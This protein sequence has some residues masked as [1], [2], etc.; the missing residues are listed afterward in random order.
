[1]GCDLHKKDDLKMKEYKKTE[2]EKIF[3]NDGNFEPRN[4]YSG[5]DYTLEK[6]YALLDKIDKLVNQYYEMIVPGITEAPTDTN[7][8]Y[9]L[10]FLYWF[11]RQEKVNVRMLLYKS[12]H[13]MINK[14]RKASSDLIDEKHTEAN[15][16]LPIKANVSE[17]LDKIIDK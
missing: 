7:K 8:P 1:M 11:G 6:E 17:L 15:V 5:H 14:I 2:E 13:N 4:F 9:T 10:P 3:D 12:A 16:S